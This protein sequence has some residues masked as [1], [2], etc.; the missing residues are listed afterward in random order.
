VA[1][2]ARTDLAPPR[3]LSLAWVRVTPVQVLVAV[4][5]ASAIAR[6]FVGWLRATPVYFPD[7]YIYSQSTAARSSG[8]ARHISPRYCSPC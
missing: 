1:A 3:A 7:E 6:T 8:A 2:D 5:A 4:V